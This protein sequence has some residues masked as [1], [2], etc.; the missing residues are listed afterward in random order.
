MLIE[1]SGG[2][3]LHQRIHGADQHDRVLELLLGEILLRSLAFVFFGGSQRL[4]V[5]SDFGKLGVHDMVG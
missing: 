4:G 2:E 3:V 5:L 1:G